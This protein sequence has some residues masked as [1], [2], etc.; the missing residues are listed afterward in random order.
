MNIDTKNSSKLPNVKT[1]I[2]TT[3]G[4]LARKHKAL[5]LSQGF[6][7]FE[8]D[9]NL[10]SLVNNA[11]MEGHNQYASMQGYFGLREVISEKIQT[12]HG[13][14]YHPE[15]ELT[16]TVGATQSIYTAISAFVHVGDEVIVLKPAYDCYEPAILVNGGKPVFL[17]LDAPDYSIDWEAFKAK[18]T[19]K[20]KMLIINTPHNPSGKILS[21]NDMLWLQEI[22]KDTNILVLSDE[23]YEHIVFDGQQHQSVS[24]FPDL[25]QRSFVC[26]SFGKTFH[27]TG[28]KMGYCAAPKALMEEFR[29]VHQ[30]AVFCVD[31]PVQR[32]LAEYLKTPE[33]YLGLNDFYQRKRDLFLKGLAYSNFKFIPSQ[34]TYFQLLDYTQITQESDEDFAKKL[35][36]EHKLASIP[37]SSFNVN[38]RDD[39]VLRFC[40]A[41]KEETLERA[42]EILSSL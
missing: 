21:Q 19:K 5:D 32:A 36:L 11:M 35:I 23:V 22:L 6:P 40:F 33:H 25:A 27:V 38:D 28:W 24:R 12:L 16:I 31:H 3:V 17:Q 18:I 29:K 10:I 41:K 26:A 9:P 2:F 13:H 4:N 7:N 15:N 39:K 30:F 14:Q 34:G 8:A 20:T 42:V 37:I 1:T